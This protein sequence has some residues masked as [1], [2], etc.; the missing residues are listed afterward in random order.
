MTIVVSFFRKS[1]RMG[2]REI[3]LAM[4]S[5]INNAIPVAVA[6]AAAG[7]ITGII[8]LTGVGLRFSSILISLSGNSEFLMLIL[9]MI[10]SIILGM[11]LPTSAAYIILAVLTAPALID[12]GVAPLAAHFFIFFFG[13]I[14]T[15]TPP[16]A[17]S[18]YAAA[19]I[20]GSNPMKTG[21]TAFR[22]GL[23]GFIVPFLAI[24]RPAILLQAELWKIF[25]FTLLAIISIVG[26]TYSTVGF[27]DK[28]LSILERL[29]FLVGA[30]LLLIRLDWVLNVAGLFI[31]A[32]AFYKT[33]LKENADRLISIMGSESVKDNKGNLVSI[34]NFLKRR[35]KG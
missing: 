25:I 26:L 4:E 28:R 3:L 14:S 23:I 7:I 35:K 20:A 31:L 29:L 22:L 15:I 6:C 33:H 8:S 9:T 2:L 17:L 24:Y 21:F 27:R 19:G 12:L 18:A 5:G 32:F 1:T 11:G 13:C 16:V 30:I 10:A 34:L